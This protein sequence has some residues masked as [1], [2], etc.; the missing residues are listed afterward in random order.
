MPIAWVGL[1]FSILCLGGIQRHYPTINDPSTFNHEIPKSINELREQ[2]VQCLMLD[3]YTKGGQF[4]LETFLQYCMIEH[5][6]CP[7]AGF[8]IW[9]LLGM[10]KPIVFRMGLHRDP[11]HFPRL[12][13]FVGEM[14]RRLWATFFQLDIG[15]S[16]LAGLPRMITPR[17]CDT[18]N[19]LNILDSD[20]DEN[21]HQLPLSRPESEVT[22]MLFL[23]A[24]TRLMSIGGLISD[25]FHDTTSCLDIELTT[26]D[27]LLRDTREYL[28]PSLQSRPLSLSI[29]DDPRVIL[30]RAYLDMFFLKMRITLHKKYL[31][32]SKARFPYDHTREVC[33][34]SA[35]KILEYHHSI[36][37]ESQDGGRLSAVRWAFASLFNHD[38]MLAAS[39]LCYHIKQSTP[40]K[41]EDDMDHDTLTKIRAMLEKSHDIWARSS[42]VS[43][44]AQKAVQSLSII[45]AAPQDVEIIENIS[46]HSWDLFA[47]SDWPAFQG[48]P[49]AKD[50]S[51]LAVDFRYR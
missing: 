17:Q 7:D 11:K 49:S 14:R 18:E 45:L 36:D 2:T 23:L 37:E 33:L 50:L 8:Q 20:F 46:S 44:E 32:V 5:F 22:P 31:S 3:K 42:A 26:F 43:N 1:L 35:F 24:K 6:L 9:I 27:N 21:T 29:M 38:F 47:E 48:V 41:E 12:S 15:F 30:Q 34:D 51:H 25:Q 28:P 4:V 16:S 10:L 13:P 40:A 19:P 39:V